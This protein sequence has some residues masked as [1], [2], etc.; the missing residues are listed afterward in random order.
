M[1]SRMW[2]GP[3][4]PTYHSSL[5]PKNMWRGDSRRP[6]DNK[7]WGWLVKDPNF[8]CTAH[9]TCKSY[10]GGRSLT[11]LRCLIKSLFLALNNKMNTRDQL[12]GLKKPA[13][14]KKI[15]KKYNGMETLVAIHC[16][17]NRLLV[18]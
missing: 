17:R 9:S 12:K 4:P 15:R 1:L 5:E 6:G 3:K 8:E 13:L 16:R 18:D 7:I 2:S 14:E 11:G 10:S